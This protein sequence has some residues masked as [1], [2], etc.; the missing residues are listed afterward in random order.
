MGRII[1]VIVFLVCSS[2]NA[3]SNNDSLLHLQLTRTITGS[4]KNFWV[5]NL[6][7]FYTT[8]N[9]NQVKK[10]TG[11]GDS[12]GIFND[13]KRY[14]SITTIDATNPLRLLVYYKDFST[15]LLLDRFLNVLTRIDLRTQ[16]LLQISAVAQ[17]YDNKIWLYDDLEA[18]LKKIDDKGNVLFESADF[19]L[20]FND[21]P[22]PSAIIDNSGQL[23]L[24]DA[25]T[26][27]Y[28]FDYY[29][30]IKSKEP[31]T[32]WSDVDVH[33]NQLIG[34]DSNTIFACLPKQLQCNSIN[35]N[36][37]LT[38]FSVVRFANNKL[39]ALNKQGIQVYEVSK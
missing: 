39:Y 35:T 29:G 37:T 22:H 38:D 10:F 9:R 20:L 31:F 13:V 32:N 6:G 8:D 27:W 18:R 11:N 23:Y 36:L 33:Y 5:D 4:Y 28:I 30:A 16:N 25:K 7:N 3:R 1:F 26:G 24:Y 17:S 2:V 19:R 34:R 21:V 12:V 14:G 15:I